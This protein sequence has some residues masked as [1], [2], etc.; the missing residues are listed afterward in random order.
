[1]DIDGGN[2]TAKGGTANENSYGICSDRVLSVSG[3]NVT[4]EAGSAGRGSIG[5]SCDLKISGGT[6][7]ATGGNAL[8]SPDA[9]DLSELSAYWWRISNS[10]PYYES[11][12]YSYSWDEFGF[13]EYLEIRDTNPGN[14]NIAVVDAVNNIAVTV[15]APELG[16]TPDYNP[17]YTSTPENSVKIDTEYIK[18]YKI[19]EADFTGTDKDI[20]DSMG[21]NEKFTT[22]YYYYIDM[23]FY[24]NAGYKIT[25]STTGT[26]NGMHHD[27][28]YYNLYQDNSEAFAYV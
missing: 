3:G 22:G 6:L 24:P 7:K 11:S 17:V 18:W 1:M 10:G 4:A 28:P 2:V 5:I 9:P 15:T 27:D 13:E 14:G 12:N 26:V 20:W 16:A 19:A 25:T 21:P 23:Y 8:N